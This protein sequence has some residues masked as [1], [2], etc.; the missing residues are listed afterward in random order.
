MTLVPD[1]TASPAYRR[2]VLLSWTVVFL[3]V[4]FVVL[5]VNALPQL[6]PSRKTGAATQPMNLELRTA[7]RYAV[8][9][10]ALTKG[11]GALDSKGAT[12]QPAS[13]LLDPVDRA[14]KT[15]ED[16]I[17]AATVAGEI[18]GRDAALS[19]LASIQV[20]ADAPDLQADVSSLR[21][22]YSGAADELGDIE[23]QPLIDHLGW[24]GR[25]ALAYGKPAS[26]PQHQAVIAPA[27]R[28]AV[29]VLGF[30]GAAL[31]L[32]AVGVVLLV[33]A[34]VL[35]ATGTLRLWYR[36]VRPN[37]P[38]AV[39]LESFALSIFLLMIVFQFAVALLVKTPG[40]GVSLFALALV[41][42][43]LWWPVFRGATWGE[44]L[45]AIGW[46]LGPG[47]GA[48]RVFRE[49]GSAVVGYIAG[50]PFLAG[51]FWVSQK[52]AHWVNVTPTHPIVKEL[53]E[54]GWR[55]AQVYVLACVVAPILEETMFRGALFAHLRT[56]HRWPFSSVTVGVLFAAV[57]PQ[58]WTLIPV[59]GMIGVI[60]AA[61][62]EWRGS[63]V[64]SMTAHA[65][66]NGVVVTLAVM[67]LGN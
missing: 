2:S 51:A 3:A 61:I 1:L 47:T 8:G 41:P 42:L 7:A 52:L 53:T 43:I 57:H 46:N 29:F 30:A 44:S 18:E 23:R 20:P 33:L 12:S 15:P 64:A 38:R 10:H 67:L 5:A 32:L 26:D 31:V 4:G 62:R 50:I 19:R 39:F 48:W 34:V 65:L 40:F 13:A 14:A 56:W 59:L 55:V 27:R 45:F 9:A 22:I 37:V 25:L 6:K 60:L 54:G 21:M 16:R 17:R 28:A 66:S 58:G 63:I 36:P 24:F 11:F 49:M 35:V